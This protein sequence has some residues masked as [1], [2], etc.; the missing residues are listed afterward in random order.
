[1]IKWGILGCGDVAEVKSGPAFQKAQNSELVAVMRRDGVKAKS[2]AQRHSVPFWYDSVEDLLANPEVNAIYVASPPIFHEEHAIKAL[3]SGKH[4]YLEK[5][6]AIDA[7]ACKRIQAVADKTGMKL[8]VAHYRRALPAF[9]KVKAL[10]DEGYIGSA[11]TASIRILQPQKSAIVAQSEENW[12]INPEVSGGGLFHDLAPH[13][14]DLMVQYFGEPLKYYGVSSNQSQSAAADDSVSAS[15]LFSS[16]LHFQGLWCFAVSENEA[17]DHC[18]IIGSKGSI[19]FSFYGEEV[20]LNSAQGKE[21]FHF[22]N[23]ENIQLPMIEK[24]TNFFL[25]QGENPCSGIEATQIIELM[26]AFT[27]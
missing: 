22:E 21:I 24:T 1:M 9:L 25:G 17:T 26:D 6:M 14:L 5:P 27:G 16:G 15:I 18:H 4:V 11:R 19:E 13:Q 12:R 23:P 2:F 20:V 8:T 7:D 10:I 3:E